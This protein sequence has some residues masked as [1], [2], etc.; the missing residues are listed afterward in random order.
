MFSS[1][2]TQVVGRNTFYIE[3]IHQWNWNRSVSFSGTFE[4]LQTFLRQ[5]WP[6]EVSLNYLTF[7]SDWQYTVISTPTASTAVVGCRHLGA[8]QSDFWLSHLLVVPSSQTG[9][10]S[11]SRTMNF[12]AFKKWMLQGSW[13]T[14]LSYKGG[15]R[16]LNLLKCRSFDTVIVLGALFLQLLTF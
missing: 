7:G 15:V 4:Y 13:P 1:H 6:C 14:H 8:Y 10:S 16:W 3:V 9:L 11:F 2:P 12:H 5:G